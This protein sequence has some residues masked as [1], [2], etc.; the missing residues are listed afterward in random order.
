MLRRFLNWL[1]H[2]KPEPDDIA[3][4]KWSTAFSFFKKRRFLEENQDNFEAFYRS[5]GFH[6]Y[7]KKRN[8]FAWA[9]YGPYRYQ[10]SVVEMKISFSP[11]NGHCSAGMMFRYMSED[12]Y[13]YAL[14]SNKGQFRFDL[15]VNGSPVCLIPWLDTPL[16][17]DGENQTLR[18]IIHNSSFSFY[19][20]DVWIA[21]LDDET[22][23]AG[24]FAFCAQN[25]DETETARVSLANM[26]VESRPVEVDI[27]FYRWTR[28]IPAPPDRRIKLAERLNGRGQH[29]AALVQLRKAFKTVGP[30]AAGLFLLA[31]TCFSLEMFG[32]ALAYIEECLKQDP[33]N[34]QARLEKANILYLQNRFMETK[35][36]LSGII[37]DF[38]ENPSVWN[39][40]GNAEYALGN[41]NGAAEAYQRAVRIDEEMPIFRL[42][43]ARAFDKAGN[44]E[45]AVAHYSEAARYFFRQEAYEDLSPVF[46]R[47]K[48]IAPD[49]PV[50]RSVCGKML[51][52]E[53]SFEEAE[54]LFLSLIETKQAESEEY[55]LEGL[56]KA[57]AG[58][59]EEA[60]DYFTSAI[61]RNPDFYLYW[62]KKA[63]SEYFSGKDPHASLD[64]ARG[65]APDDGW[66]RNLTGLI[67][68][69]HKNYQDAMAELEEARRILPDE[70]EIGINLSEA[71][72]HV[73]GIEAAIA[74]LD[75]DKGA[76]NNQ[77]GNLYAGMGLLDEAIEYYRAAVQLESLN[78]IFRENLAAA[79]WDAGL[80]HEAEE[81]LSRLLEECPSPRGY[82]LIGQV[83]YEKGE[84]SRA[85]AAWKAALELNPESEHLRLLFARGLMHSGDLEQAGQTAEKLLESSEGENARVL[86]KRI[87]EVT[88]RSYTCDACGREWWVPRDIPDQKQ[89]KLIGE[90][91][92]EM[93]AGKCPECGRVYCVGC[94]SKHLKDSRFMCPHC[95]LG[96]KLMDDGLKYLALHYVEQEKKQ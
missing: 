35:N 80:I 62:L 93:P 3:Q 55:F 73:E 29:T 36:Y 10:N 63:E 27:W 68:L 22:I 56:V 11:E 85:V 74:L 45:Q 87:H 81:N 76:S 88:H 60:C 52:S 46:E 61:E 44:M 75:R 89:L 92:S 14:V 17:P 12:N 95:E 9:L 66:V 64:K 24:Y 33:R 84:Y 16:S 41:W 69:E 40:M 59:H 65:L 18:V 8:L 96:L 43:A 77:A 72:F 48:Q 38:E 5:G 47:M 21:E 58:D 31:E 19:L 78:P 70:E 6:L 28:F 23:S 49:N 34:L 37:T 30:D 54:Q 7:L 71:V 20:N 51:F 1:P 67:Y 53:G 57:R 39:L 91:P 2:R 86:L 25:Y 13:Y 90:P 15:V 83:A 79:L 4:E 50:Y 42:N 26:R 82:E 94:A 32:D